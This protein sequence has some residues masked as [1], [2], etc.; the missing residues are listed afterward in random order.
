M[1]F[2]TSLPKLSL[3]IEI[4]KFRLQMAEEAKM[5]CTQ[6]ETVHSSIVVA[7]D[8][9]LDVLAVPVHG[10]KPH[11][12]IAD[13]WRLTGEMRSYHVFGGARVLWHFTDCAVKMLSEKDC[14]VVVDTIGKPVVEVPRDLAKRA[15]G[16][17]FLNDDDLPR[18]SRY[19][20][21]HSMLELCE[22]RSSSEKTG[23]CWRVRKKL[24]FSGPEDGNP[25]LAPRIAGDDVDTDL[26][27]LDDTG[28]AFR[29]DDSLWPAAISRAKRGPWIVYKLH[30]PL[31]G[32]IGLSG[33]AIGNKLWNQVQPEHNEKCVVIVDVNDLREQGAVI[34]RGLSWEKTASELLWHLRGDTRFAALR[35]CQWLVVRLGLEGALVYR[36]YGLERLPD[37]QLVFNP[38]CIEDYYEDKYGPS[39]VGAGSACAA[40]LATRLL[41]RV[42]NG[43]KGIPR[44]SDKGNDPGC[45]VMDAVKYGL[46]A[47]VAVFE[48]GF[49][50]DPSSAPQYPS[51][52]ELLKLEENAGKLECVNVPVFR[53][54][55][56]ADPYGW[57]ILDAR[58]SPGSKLEEIVERALREDK[59]EDLAGIPLGEFHYLR[60]Y[61]RF[62]IEAYRSLCAILHE[63]LHNPAPER[64]LTIAV[65]GPPGSG[66]SF[67]VKQVA[68]FVKGDIELD[69]PTFNLSQYGDSEEL[70]AAFHLIRDSSVRGR[71]PLVFFDEFDARVNKEPLFWLKH[72]LAPMQDGLF[73]DRGTTHP[74][75][76]AVFVFAGGTSQSFEE[77]NMEPDSVPK[78]GG[79]TF[80]EFKEA[81]GPDFVSRLRAR[82][83]IT[84]VEH[85][86]LPTARTL[87]R[88][89]AILRF[90]F[91]NKAHEAFDD[92]K[93]LQIDSNLARA[94]LHV[95][96]YRHGVRSME[97]LLDMS[98]LS[99]RRRITPSC[100]PPPSQMELHVN[101]EEFGN[102]LRAPSTFGKKDL[103]LI[104]RSIHDDFLDQ[105]LKDNSFDPSIPA[106]RT[107]EELDESVETYKEVK[108]SNRDQARMIPSRL[109]QIG[110]FV[111]KVKE[112]DE[113]IV[114]KLDLPPDEIEQ[115]A[116]ILYEEFSKR[117]RPKQ[118][119]AR[120]NAGNRPEQLPEWKTL[121]PDKQE[122][123]RDIIKYAYI[124]APV[125]ISEAA[126]STDRVDY[127]AKQEHERWVSEKL[128]SGWVHGE[129]RN[130]NLR[131]HPSIVKWEDSRLL[132]TE[133]DKD[134]RAMS[135]IP[136]YLGAA[137]WEI[138]FEEK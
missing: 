32:C 129:P 88:R 116:R 50:P 42:K 70:A 43:D 6:N 55:L 7:G 101:A 16:D 47:S 115:R 21:V 123:W 86:G 83:D 128:R 67:G 35:D 34:S 106:H 8:I 127:L 65:F 94:L 77:F 82:L 136:S 85:E 2:E 59:V 33:E 45:A 126:L 122:K 89:A 119:T 19:E 91:K 96:R 105:R 52:V 38:Q 41:Y 130:N 24:G 131:M 48:A 4:E 20:I 97:A 12:D 107:W 58:F 25:T 13:N 31:P 73:L 79:Y 93:C 60:T 109:R 71:V 121:D 138:V 57:S 95:P 9:C 132:K 78:V 124:H 54:P 103:E 63:Y 117:V 113:A 118:G 98:R 100:L 92:N 1:L 23:K 133:K 39:M 15:N 62:E 11:D 18:L 134:T 3:P 36:N 29:K 99:R 135:M 17:P 5:T 14:T 22:A 125:E 26:V 76:K 68:E 64:P 40:W 61:D 111:R 87:L 120:D 110:A 80:K 108:D 84:G 112:V 114:R 56:Q 102:L 69:G 28:N 49:R 90:Q 53:D 30:R 51:K 10:K 81:K 46:A 104:A 74:I 72:F 27:L 66:K 137:G 37:V 75:G 44:E